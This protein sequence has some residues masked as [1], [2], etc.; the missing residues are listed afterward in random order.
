MMS[1]CLLNYLAVEKAQAK[2]AKYAMVGCFIIV[3]IEIIVV[4]IVVKKISGYL[5]DFGLTIFPSCGFGK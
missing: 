3:T 5:S 1:G 4:I 2:Q